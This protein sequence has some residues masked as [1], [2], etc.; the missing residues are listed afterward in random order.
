MKPEIVSAEFEETGGILVITW[1]SNNTDIK[2]TEIVAE[3]QNG[4]IESFFAE[5]Y[6][7]EKQINGLNSSATYYISVIELNMCGRMFSSDK[8]TV[9]GEPSAAGKQ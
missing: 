5:W 2:Q 9:K 6:R 1:Q 4:S 8:S 3:N 7:R